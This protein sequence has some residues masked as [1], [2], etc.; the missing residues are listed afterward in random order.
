MTRGY[1]CLP[2]NHEKLSLIPQYPCESYPDMVTHHLNSRNV[3]HG[4]KRIIGLGLDKVRSCLKKIKHTHQHPCT[5]FTWLAHTSAKNINKKTVLD[6]T[7]SFILWFRWMVRK[8][9]SCLSWTSSKCLLNKMFYI[10][11]SM[12]V[13]FAI[14]SGGG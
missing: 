3:G 4:A 13:E 5:H 10:W 11:I 9:F 14:S 12:F 1:E 6:I 2:Y 8:C 7:I